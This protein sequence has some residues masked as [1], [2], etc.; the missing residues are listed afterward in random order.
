MR[1]YLAARLFQAVGVVVFVT[2]FSFVLIHLAPGDPVA[3][4]LRGPNVSETV[5]EQW[6]ATYGLDRP[7]PEQYARWLLSTARGELGYSFSLH[8]PVRDVFLDA[9]PNT[10][11][12]SGTALLLSFG[13]GMAV[14]VLQAE[15][16]RGARDRWMGRTLLVFFSVPDFWFALVILILFAYRLPW[17]PA[18][19]LKDSFGYDYLPPL[20]KVR[21]R[22]W[23]LALPVFTLTV[24]T[25]ANAARQQRAALIAVLP[26]DWMRTALAKGLSWRA[27]V[28]KHAF[29][30][31]LLP[32]ITLLGI[33]VPQFAAG[34]IFVEKVFTWPG[35]GLLTVNAIGAR[36]Y[37]LVTSGVLVASIIVVCAALVADIAVAIADPRI[38]LS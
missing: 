21:D 19:G 7:L 13:L 26:S 14:G 25:A 31:A 22:L 15:R 12:L 34:S 2:T 28:R 23:H 30:N 4:A 5:R 33:S 20:A 38:R 16:P 6:R 27:A 8:R 1:R 29:R 24:L 17:F 18:G 36:D 32:T 11:L 3:G 9:L 37:P 10:L 35:V